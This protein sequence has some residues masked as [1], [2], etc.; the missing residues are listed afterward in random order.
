M[1]FRCLCLAL[2]AASVSAF[3]P[4]AAVRPAAVVRPALAARVSPIFA[5]TIPEPEDS[6]QH[7]PNCSCDDP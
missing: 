6:K 5:Y 3:A 2:V 1:A 4:A 7:A